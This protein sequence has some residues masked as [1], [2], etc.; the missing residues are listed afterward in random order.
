LTLG[1]GVGLA[2]GVG[3]E[4]A[5]GTTDGEGCGVVDG[6]AAE[7]VGCGAIV[8]GGAGGWECV[9][10]IVGGGGGGGAEPFTVMVPCM[11]SKW[12]EQL[13]AYVPGEVK[14]QDPRLP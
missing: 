11:L 7:W 1:L 14:A 8:G 6:A 10:L 12:T 13:K 3:E 9:G 2:S 5:C 4:S